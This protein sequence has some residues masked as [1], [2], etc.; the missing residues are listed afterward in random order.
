MDSYY[1]SSVRIIYI[2]DYYFIFYNLIR[3]RRGQLLSHL[4]CLILWN[5]QEFGN[6]DENLLPSFSY[7]YDI[8]MI[9]AFFGLGW[10]GMGLLRKN[11]YARHYTACIQV[12][13][14]ELPVISLLWHPQSARYPLISLSPHPQWVQ[15]QRNP[16]EPNPT[17]S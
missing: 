2:F 15:Y 6:L 10:V 8:E 16:S 4:W 11:I 5:K 13:I 3:L 1:F 9:S 14:E 7:V 12:K 17:Q